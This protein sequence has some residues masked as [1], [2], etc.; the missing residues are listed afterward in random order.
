MTPT[1]TA[2]T[3]L[4]KRAAENDVFRL[5]VQSAFNHIIITDPDGVVVYANSAVERITG[6]SLDEVINAT[7]RLW[8][9][10]MEPEVY[11]ELWHTIKEKKE[12]YKGT[13][14]NKR[15]DGTTYYAKAVISPILDDAGDVIGFIGTEEDVTKEHEVDRM[16]TE[17]ISIAAHQLKTPL[18]T[19]QWNL[20][21]LADDVGEHESIAQAHEAVGRLVAMVTALLNITRIESGRLTVSPKE[22]NITSLVQSLVTQSQ[23]LLEQKKLSLTTDIAEGIAPIITDPHLV[24]E[25]VTNYLSNAIKYT[26]EGGA[27]TV[28]VAEEGKAVSI[29][30]T[31]TGMG[32]PKEEHHR[33]FSKFFRSEEA[34]ASATEGNG[35]G[36]YFVKIVADACNSSVHFES[37]EGKGSTFS[38]VIPK[39]ALPPVE[40]EISLTATA[41]AS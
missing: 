32:I 28:R 9:G 17:F 13:I 30:V 41:L 35:L 10:Q 5:A 27:V 19:I 12:P 7:P 26:P 16:K 3:Q 24:A 25:V 18:T 4:L 15:K 33:V 39:E 36:L 37:E 21:N 20:E 11:K 40:G 23:P 2:H 22:T 8:G 38:I 29:A 1:N 34:K 31:D 6:Y 14:T